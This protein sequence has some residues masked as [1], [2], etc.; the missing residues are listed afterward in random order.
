MLIM[1]N[2]LMKNYQKINEA[3]ENNELIQ[4]KENFFL[5]SYFLSV[6]CV[7]FT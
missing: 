4:I 6:E 2:N 7:M 1:P 5:I 3:K